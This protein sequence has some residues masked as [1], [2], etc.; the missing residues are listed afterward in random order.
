M[1]MEKT[2]DAKS[3]F[4]RTCAHARSILAELEGYF[5]EQI[6]HSAEGNSLLIHLQ[7]RP[8][9][10]DVIVLLNGLRYLSVGDTHDLDGCFVDELGLTFIPGSQA[11]WPEGLTGPGPRGSGLPDMVWLRIIGPTHVEAV[12]TI[13]Q[14]FTS[15]LPPES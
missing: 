9:R 2:L 8:T 14:I 15:M 5:I 7:E 11:Q 10:P 4:E 12:A 1:T 3:G 6:C 13:V